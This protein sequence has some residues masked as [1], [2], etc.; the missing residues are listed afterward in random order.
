[1]RRGSREVIEDSGLVITGVRKAR[2]EGAYTCSASSSAGSRSMT[3]RLTV[4][5]ELRSRSLPC[6]CPHRGDASMKSMR[7]PF[8]RRYH[9]AP[10]I[11]STADLFHRESETF[12]RLRVF[13]GCLFTARRIASGNSV[14]LSVRP[15]VR[16]SVTRRY[17]VKTTARSTVQF[18]LS[19]SKMCLV[20]YKPK[21]I[22]Q[23]RRLLPEILARSDLLPDSSESTRFV[24]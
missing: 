8:L 16:P 3:A 12:F 19:D 7:F 11:L 13:I 10:Q 21:N 17:C 9:V 2:D 24:L 15:S 22:P 4:N 1:V 20:L 18:T 23:G 14:R 5:G 6:A